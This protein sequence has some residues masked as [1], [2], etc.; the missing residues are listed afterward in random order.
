MA[1]KRD[2]IV[3]TVDP[4][5]NQLQYLQIPEETWTKATPVTG[6]LAIEIEK[7][8]AAGG[9]LAAMPEAGAGGIGAAC[10]LVN[11]SS[12]KTS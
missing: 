11:I 2:I 9:I 10:Y 1:F 5:S 12:I 8:V 6:D 3:A 4:T 7:M